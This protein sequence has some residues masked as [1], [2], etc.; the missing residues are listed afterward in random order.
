[1]TGQGSKLMRN[2]IGI[3]GVIVAGLVGSWLHYRWNQDKQE[4]QAGYKRLEAELNQEFKRDKQVIPA[5]GVLE[6]KN[7]VDSG[8]LASPLDF[9][10]LRGVLVGKWTKKAESIQDRS[11]QHTIEF[12]EKSIEEKKY[13]WLHHIGKFDKKGDLLSFTDRNGE[14]NVYGL[15]F[16]SDGEIA[17]RPEKLKNGTDFNGL[18]GQWQRISLPQGNDLASLGTG[19]IA[20]AKRQVKRIEQKEAKL[21]SLLDMTLADR[22]DLVT[23]L[24]AVGVQTTADL[25]GNLRGQR[26]AENITKI[27]TEI[28][29]LEGQLAAIDTVLLKAKSIVRRMEREQAGLSEDEMR[30]M[31]EQ[32]REV[33]ER[34]DGAAAAPTTPLDIDVAV[35]KALKAKPRSNQP[36]TR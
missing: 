23:K 16:L 33:E 30:K 8:P 29:G 14:L 9:T 24:R 18:A 15:E 1:M 2:V 12:T 6:L 25:K 31:A 4:T 27:T 10:G 21:Q 35:E 36:K 20:D 17:L 13:G 5:P 22:D 19:P 11:E 34:T 26:L 28:E 7:K 32:L 3:L